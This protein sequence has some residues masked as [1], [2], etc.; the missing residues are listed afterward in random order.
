MPQQKS[1]S[2][3]AAKVA[4][5]GVVMAEMIEE[6]MRMERE[7]KRLRHHV[8]VLSKR[9]HELMKDGKSRAVSFI[10]SDTSLRD[11]ESD[12]E[13]EEEGEEE[14]VRGGLMRV[15]MV[16]TGEQLLEVARD[17]SEGGRKLEERLGLRLKLGKEEVAQGSGVVV[18]ESVA[19]FEEAEVAK[20]VVRLP[21]FE[22]VEGKKRRLGGDEDEEVLI[23]PLGP[24][25]ECGGLL[26]RVGRESVFVDADPRLVAGGGSTPAAV[27]VSRWSEALRQSPGVSG[28]YQLRPRVGGFRGRGYGG[29]GRGRG[30]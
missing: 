11:V 3:S 13:D 21:R 6:R 28:G 29:Y 2:F 26:R 18:A 30:V 15:T 24:R 12:E 5:F 25:A 19:S 7:I 4:N 14:I 27:G 10:A 22:K 23:A 8:S 9:N 16:G 1:T 20:P 17:A